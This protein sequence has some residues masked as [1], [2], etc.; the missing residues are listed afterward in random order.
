MSL[1][2]EGSEFTAMDGLGLDTIRPTYIIIETTTDESMREKT[3]NYLVKF[4]YRIIEQLTPNDA[5]YIDNSS[6]QGDSE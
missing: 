2:V 1:D 3:Y 5:F 4:N 6:E